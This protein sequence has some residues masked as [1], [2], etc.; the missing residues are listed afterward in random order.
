VLNPFL[1]RTE[2]QMRHPNH[3]ANPEKL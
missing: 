1:R 2:Q 3:V